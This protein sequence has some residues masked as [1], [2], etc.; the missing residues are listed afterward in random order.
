L[1]VKQLR[2][3]DEVGLLR[4]ARVD[5][6]TGCR[7]YRRDQ[8]RDAVAIALLRQLD[9]PLAAIGVALT[10]GAEVRAEV[11]RAEQ[12]RL[13]A[14]IAAQRRVWQA[15]DRLLADGLLAQEVVMCRE[16]ARR[17]LVSHTVCAPEE[18]GA[19]TGRCVGQLM[20]AVRG[21]SWT[22]PLWG[23]FPVDLPAQVLVTV[24]VETNG[25]ADDL[26]VE[27]LPAGPAERPTSAR[28]SCW[29]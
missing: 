27:H 9:V 20:A 26:A 2:H 24:G 25:S 8:V 3:Y 6:A 18:I 23:L 29:R 7:Y 1:S 16:P 14:R 21:V 15:L 17:L 19:A 28:T 22:P 11:L 10:G 13:E 5:E 12:S 4:P